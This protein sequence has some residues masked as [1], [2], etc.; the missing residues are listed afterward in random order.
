MAHVVRK[1]DRCTIDLDTTGVQILVTQR[2]QYV[3]GAKPPMR[4]LTP[5]EQSRFET[6]FEAAIRASWDNRA[7]MRAGGTS[8]LATALAGKDIP[9]R[10]DIMP[11]ATR[12]H[13]KVVVTNVPE[14]MFVTSSVLWAPAPLRSTRTTSNGATRRAASQP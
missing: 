8:D 3:W 4:M 9:V 12:A 6:E 13:W 5:I 10:V 1:T 14:D 11:V 2:W 7:T